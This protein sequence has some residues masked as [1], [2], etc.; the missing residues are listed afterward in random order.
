MTSLTEENKIGKIRDIELNPSNGK[1][2]L[3]GESALW[4]LSK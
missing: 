2:Y 1:I 3:I 4:Q